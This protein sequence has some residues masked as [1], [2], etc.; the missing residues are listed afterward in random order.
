MLGTP[1][2]RMEVI[3]ILSR[4]GWHKSGAALDFALRFV[5]EADGADAQKRRLQILGAVIPY[6]W[7]KA[8]FE[9]AM[10]EAIR[11]ADYV[12]HGAAP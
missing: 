11:M 8:S 2:Q 10:R 3:S 12:E 1:E 7:G 5:A 4:K 6:S 9:D